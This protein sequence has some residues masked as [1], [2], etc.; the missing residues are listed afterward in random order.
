MGQNTVTLRGQVAYSWVRISTGDVPFQA[1]IFKNKE[2]EV[3]ISGQ[4]SDVRFAE[5][6]WNGE[7]WVENIS[8]S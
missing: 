5:V 8:A 7:K 1:F 4:E 6:I 2:D 3:D